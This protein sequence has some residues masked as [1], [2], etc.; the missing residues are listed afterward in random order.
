MTVR[1]STIGAAPDT[2]TVSCT[3]PT[4][5]SALTVAVNP[6][7]SSM[8]SRLT[9]EKPGSV[10]VTSYAPG[11]RSAMRYR[12][13]VSVTAKRTF[14]INAGLAASTVTPGRTAPDES[15]TTPAMLLAPVPCAHAAAGAVSRPIT[16]SKS[17]GNF[18]ISTSLCP[19]LSNRF[20]HSGAVLSA[21]A[22]R[23]DAAKFQLGAL[24]TSRQRDENPQ[25]TRCTATAPKDVQ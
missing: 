8:P 15:C 10:K 5:N 2:V 9:L 25:L 4:G 24:V 20:H 22:N 19:I 18:I 7:V 6:T 13:W 16:I 17:R 3:V 12:P 23:G 21:A 1:V 14:S 11:R